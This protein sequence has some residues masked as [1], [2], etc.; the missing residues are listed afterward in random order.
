MSK[1]TY[2]HGNLRADLIAAGLEALRHTPPGQISLRRLAA[3]VGVSANAPYTHFADKNAL[4]AAIARE[5]FIRLG[6]AM[7]AVPADST[8]RRGRL[9]GLGAA[10]LRFGQDNP[11]LYDL[12]FAQ[13]GPGLS[14]EVR[15]AG[16]SCF[17]MLYQAVEPADQPPRLSLAAWA[18]VHGLVTL[19]AAGR[20]NGLLGPTGDLGAWAPMLAELLTATDQAAPISSS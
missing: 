15:A 8:D 5:G 7:A 4:L 19:A 20:L 14:P 12:M 1:D 17:Q 2:H 10:Y 11:G 13:D 3:Q 9:G 18:M 6:Q 16:Q